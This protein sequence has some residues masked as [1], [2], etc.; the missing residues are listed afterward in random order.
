MVVSGVLSEQE[1]VES[2]PWWMGFLFVGSL[3]MGGAL[4][5]TGAG[6]A[7]GNVLANAIGSLGNP[8]LMGLV[9]F[10][11]PFLLT[12]VMMNRSVMTIFIP[13]AILACKS[14][15]ANPVGVM[16]LVQ[17]ACLSSFMTPMATPAVPMCMAAG[18][19]N[20]NSLMKQSLLPAVALC[21][22]SVG[23]VMTVFPL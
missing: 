18:G 11:V 4:T 2:I 21:I 13:I 6:E 5:Q 8:Y 9:F 20:L 12:Q 14:M 1:A 23:W 16:I 10:L 7:V 22:V 15:G 17:S 3:T 19:Y